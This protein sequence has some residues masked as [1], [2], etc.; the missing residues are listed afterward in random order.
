M[1]YLLPARLVASISL[2]AWIT[3]S[4]LF[5]QSSRSELRDQGPVY[6]GTVL[7]KSWGESSTMKGIVVKLGTNDSDYVCYDEDL[8][9]VSL[10]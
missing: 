5:A 8:L 9:R 4:S 2:C 1:S 3:S 7:N 10:V 6:L